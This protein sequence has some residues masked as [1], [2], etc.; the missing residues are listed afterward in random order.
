MRRLL[1]RTLFTGSAALAG[2]VLWGAQSASA[3]DGTDQVQEAVVDNSTTQNASA[4]V[5]SGQW[6]TSAPVTVGGMG[7]DHKWQMSVP[8]AGGGGGGGVAR[9][10]I[11]RRLPT[12]PRPPTANQTAQAVQQGQ[13]VID[14]RARRLRPRGGDQDQD[15]QREQRNRAVGRRG[16]PQRPIQ[17]VGPGLG[18]QQGRRQRHPVQRRLPTRPRPPTP[19]RPR[20]PSQQ[21]QGASSIGLG[22]PARGGDQDQDANVDNETSART[23]AAG[24]HNA[25]SNV[26][27][28][29]SVGSGGGGNVTQSNAAANTAT[30]VN[31]N[32]TA[33]AVE[34]GQA[35]STIAVA[36]GDGGHDGQGLGGTV[37]AGP[38]GDAEQQHRTV[39]ARRRVVNGQWN[40]YAPVAVFSP[41]AGSGSVSQ[42][43]SAANSATAANSNGTFQGVEQG[44]AAN[45][46]G[47]RS[48]P[49]TGRHGV[50][51][52]QPVGRCR[53]ATTSRPTS[54][55]RCGCSAP[56][57]AAVPSPSPT[58][59]PTA[60][61]PATST[62]TDQAAVQGQ[63]GSG[64]GGAG[65]DGDAG[66]N[67]TSQSAHAG[68]SNGQWNIYAPVTVFSP[69]AGSG[70]VSQSNSATN[71]ALAANANGT[72]QGVE[73][74]QAA[75]GNGRRSG[76]RQYASLSNTT[77]QS[78]NVAV[79]NIQANI[80]APVTIGSIGAGSG[81]VSQ[82]NAAANSASAFN[83]NRTF[84]LMFQAA[85]I[86]VFR[87]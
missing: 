38:D 35:A 72:F 80:Y 6:N 36:G 58:R 4:G 71:T 61:R 25:Q 54:T 48:G 26:S 67:G 47:H 81:T 77:A 21:G 43:N 45:G 65:P 51:R 27:A 33:Q 53:R 30:A 7:H 85:G 12:R 55:P 28:P 24:V 10:P 57:P 22:A 76:Q 5:S 50:Q 75:S 86:Y 59:R 19:T 74:G 14:H 40:I 9:H 56:A 70:S 42:S 13:G 15:R 87:F 16:D 8:T 34:Q 23:P 84:Q 63:A 44:Q 11:Q 78:A 52:H 46:N 1:R 60:P 49:V 66:N 68:V 64:S 32:E 69:G 18:R 62:L 83:M 82:S 79:F 73:Q 3:E 17:H 2:A 39:G 20:K 37:A 41:G 31:G 29:V